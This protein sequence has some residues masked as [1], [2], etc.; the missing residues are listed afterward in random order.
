[1]S[2]TLRDLVVSL[3]LQTDNFTR[4]IKSVNKQIQEAES[5]FRLAA[6]GIEGFEKTATGL[7]T[8][9]STLERR[10]QL[11]RDA[12]TQYEKALTAANTKLQECYNRQNDYAQRLTDAKTAQQA[13]KEQVGLAAQQYRTFAAT[14]G[15]TD[16][17]TIAS[18]ANLDQLKVEYR[19]QCAEVKK[20]TGQNAALKKSTQ[21][22]A[23]AVSQ[24]NINLNGARAAVKTTE[25]EISKCNRS[26]ALAQTNWDAAGKSI[27]QSRTAITTFG[28]QISLAESKFKLAAVG[29]KDMD[30]S[31][32]GLTAKLTMLREKL[33]LQEN[34]VTEYENALR[35][36]RE[37]LKAAQDAHDPEKIQQASDAVIDAETALN[38]AKTALAEV[39]QE[40]EQ[41]NKDLRTAQSA[42][43]EAGQSLDA[44]SKYCD[45]ASKVTG[46][47]GRTLT[48]VMTTPILAL[49]SA[50]IKA[51][52]SYESAFTSVRKTVNATEEEY[53]ALS[54]EI[55]GMSTEIATSADDIAEVVAIAGQLGIGTDY[56][57][58]FAR[59]MI[60][61]GNSTD[62]VA[63][64]AASTLA[65]FANITNMD[66]SLFGNLGST[67]VQLG[68]N[69]ATTESSIM[70]MAMRLAAAGH[71]VGLSEAQILGFATALSSVG[72]EAEMG[73]SAFSKALIKMEVAA[74]TGGEALTDFATVAGMTE[75]QFKALWDADPATAFQAFI[76][77]LSQMDEQ[78]M[79]AIATLEEIGISEIRLRDTLLR[80]TNAMVLAFWDGK[81]RGTAYVIR[82]CREM[83]VPCKVFMRKNECDNEV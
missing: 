63:S 74:A 47:V 19:A 7:S 67:L 49:G 56:L 48:T 41:T 64:E 29:I 36:A 14:L 77:G 1:M 17:A 70:M 10:L 53:A 4:N 18:K 22:A 59:T 21:N 40:I 43:T 55:K 66:Q 69:F 26:L 15:E 28:K 37:Q 58:T 44:F 24:A 79:S 73:C 32:G 54:D 62:I 76:V 61:L 6:A 71:Q 83:N 33:T 78:G 68:N 11:Q 60:D 30:A 45:K 13:L 72:I 81:S 31:V 16:S 35:G 75:A 51:S 42:W 27:E 82:K 20:L 8:Q 57:T 3:S 46:A 25:S 5:K 12:V 38:K 52:I 23:D 80:A 2:E 9:L 34:T 39:R 65:K 50:A